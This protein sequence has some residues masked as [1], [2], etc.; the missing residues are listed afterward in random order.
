VNPEA[1]ERNR[2]IVR[3]RRAR[4]RRKRWLDPLIFLGLSLGVHV[5]VSFVIIRTAEEA[6][7][8][9]ALSRG[10]APRTLQARMIDEASLSPDLRK[11]VESEEAGKSPSRP[12]DRARYR[13]ERTQR[14]ERETQAPQTGS[15]AASLPGS[16]SGAPGESA[17]PTSAPP[18]PAPDLAKLGLSSALS[19]ELAPIQ[20]IKPEGQGGG[21]AASEAKP[22][23]RDL[24]YGTNEPL[25]P[26]IAVGSR[27][28]LNTDEYV[29]AGFF[30]RLTQEV[31]PR[32]EPLV[33]RILDRQGKN[34]PPAT[35]QTLTSFTMDGEGNIV[36]VLVE[37]SSGRSELD[38]AARAALRQVLR[39]RNPPLALRESDGYIRLKLGFTLYLDKTGFRFNY[40]PDPRLSEGSN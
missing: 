24:R 32:W 33:Q 26:R 12:A 3:L 35:Y 23:R 11:V 40:V 18:K 25:D 38:E 5:L 22:G 10:V 7:K 20:E 4:A 14:V 30:N 39:L 17:A 29:Y 2:E 1:I 36:D 8:K 31:R 21:G 9:G 15:V 16:R 27:T 34:I 6:E 13:G 19:P 37:T 28:I